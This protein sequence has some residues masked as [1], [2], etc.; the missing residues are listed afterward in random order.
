MLRGHV[1]SRW[2]MALVCAG[3]AAGL[4]ACS[5]TSAW[6]PWHKK[7]VPPQPQAQAEPAPPPAH[8][9]PRHRKPVHPASPRKAEA[10]PQ[11]AMV[12]P[13][14]LA[15]LT[16]PAVTRLLGPPAG[17]SKDEMSLV[18]T[19]TAD[20]CALKVYFY[21]DI[22]TSDFHVLKFSLAGADGKPLDADAPCRQK[23]LALRAND[24]G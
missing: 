2:R 14:T 15:G 5:H 8:E 17:T 21:P 19:Y 3:L 9:E 22:K 10:E 7:E 4:S 20:G 18:W 12:D 16:P 23:L 11:I 13:N 6:L 1:A 24:A